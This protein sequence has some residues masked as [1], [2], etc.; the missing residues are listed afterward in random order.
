MEKETIDKVNH[1]REIQQQ[2]TQ[3]LIEIK[4]IRHQRQS[5]T[6]PAEPQAAEQVIVKATD[7]LAA[8]MTGLQIQQAVDSDDLKDIADR[9]K[10]LWQAIR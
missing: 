7:K 3:A 2:I 4:Q 10:G 1:A 9:L 6:T 8:L 5:I